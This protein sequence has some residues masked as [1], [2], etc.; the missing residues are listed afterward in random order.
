MGEIFAA[1]VQEQQA[2]VVAGTRTAGCVAVGEVRPLADGSAL[3]YAAERVYTPV[4]HRLLNGAGVVPNVD[5]PMSL[6]DLAAGRDPQLAAAEAV[7]AGR[8][9]V[10]GGDRSQPAPEGSGAPQ[11]LL[12]TPL[13]SGS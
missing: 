13:S 4:Q 11:K 8:Q 1:A 2:G 6:D 10:Q 5:A 7:L 3:E 12:P 9:P